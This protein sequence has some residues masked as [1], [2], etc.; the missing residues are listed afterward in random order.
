VPANDSARLTVFQR[1]SAEIQ[2]LRAEGCLD[3]K[4]YRLL[5]DAI[6]KSALDEPRA[7]VVDVTNLVVPSPS[8]WSV[9]TSARW[10]ACQ[11]RDVMIA[12]VC[13]HGTG[14][15]VIERNGVTRYVPVY[16]SIADAI[17]ALQ[18]GP[19]P[20]V[21]R[22]VRVQLPATAASVPRSR[23]LV[24]EVLTDWSHPE[25]IPVAKLVA[26]VLVENA[27]AHT[28]SAPAL[29]LECDGT[30]V[31]VAVDDYNHVPAMRR[32]LGQHGR[33]DVSGLAILASLC[34]AWGNSPT[35]SGKTVWAVIGPENR[36]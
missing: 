23:G 10:H 17:A 36:L 25:L 35:P 1:E 30:V 24:S 32:E 13:E 20:A 6:I 15:E 33:D 4:T 2:V 27:L 26:T 34:R 5:R 31:H 11:W 19:G 21:R 12:I 22:R 8:A 14:R 28:D 3:S 7:V 16:P 18:T 29:R 9:F